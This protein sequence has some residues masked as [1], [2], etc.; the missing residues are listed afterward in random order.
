VAQTSHGDDILLGFTTIFNLTFHSIS[1]G[2]RT[3]HKSNPRRGALRLPRK[4]ERVSFR[5][6]QQR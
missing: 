3:T 5:R 2:T 1:C 6:T 4:K